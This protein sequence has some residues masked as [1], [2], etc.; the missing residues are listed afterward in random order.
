MLWQCWLGDR[1]DIRPVRT[2][3]WYIGDDLSGA[4]LKQ[5]WLSPLA[6]PLSPAAAKS[7]MLWHSGNSLSRL[8][9]NTADKWVKQWWFTYTKTLSIL[10]TIFPGGPVLT[11]TTTS[12]FWILLELQM[13]EVAVTTGAIRWTESPVKLSPPTNQHPAFY[14]PH[15]LPV[16]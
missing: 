13:M 8:S 1:R 12:P 5:F 11:S 15:A 16:A 7:R 6:P 14:R 9:W 4:C 3:C 2:E 10:T